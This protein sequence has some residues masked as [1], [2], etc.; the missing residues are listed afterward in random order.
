MEDESVSEYKDGDV[1][2]ISHL[3]ASKPP[4]LHSKSWYRRVCSVDRGEAGGV[5][6]RWALPLSKTG[7]F[8]SLTTKTPLVNRIMNL[9]RKPLF[10]TQA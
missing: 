6:E 4:L 7:L 3:Y 5:F 2:Y 8:R 9:N 1:L 10:I